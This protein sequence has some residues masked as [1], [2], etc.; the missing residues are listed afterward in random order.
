MKKEN[1]NKEVIPAAMLYYVVSDPVVQGQKLTKEQLEELW[2]KELVMKGLVNYEDDICDKL[3]EDL[4]KASYSSKVISVSTNKE[5][6]FKKGSEIC[7]TETFQKLSDYV[8]EKML[9][10]GG[11]IREGEIEKKPYKNGEKTG[12]TYCPYRGVCGFDVSV[13]GYCYEQIVLSEEEAMS[14]IVSK[15]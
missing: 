4:R 5:G 13:P 12:C 15:E 1:K 7:S 11:R 6:A 8:N 3:D 14:K 2:D 9:E 10:I